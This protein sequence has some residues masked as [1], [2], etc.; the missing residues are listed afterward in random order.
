MLT[1]TQLFFPQLNSTQ[2]NLTQLN[3][4]HLIS[5]GSVCVAL[6]LPPNPVLLLLMVLVIS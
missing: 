5:C 3:P 2:F 1:Q 4:L 6:P